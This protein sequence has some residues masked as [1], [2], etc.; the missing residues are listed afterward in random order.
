[1]VVVDFD[2]GNPGSIMNMF[3]RLGVSIVLTRDPAA[4]A[5]AERLVLPGVGA[6]DQGMEN[7]EKLGLKEVLSKRV[8]EDRIPVLGIC[9]GMQLMTL[10]SE[11]G[12]KPGLGWVDAETVHLRSG[13]LD[14]S[15]GMKFPHIGWNFV[16]ARKAHPLLENLSADPRF[17]FVHTY[18]VA[19]HDFRDVLTETFCGEIR[20]TSS[21]VHGNIAGVQFHPE[22]SHKFGARLLQNF[23][24]WAGDRSP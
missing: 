18:K 22:K 15:H 6:F 16:E 1:M 12:V 7:L 10:K 3:K 4:I 21:F 20:F 9:L 19:C 14:L 17:Y 13:A 11:E 2:M 23:S 8:R 5:S 24:V